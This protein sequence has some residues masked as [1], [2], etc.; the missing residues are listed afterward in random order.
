MLVISV[1]CVLWL[2]L[3]FEGAPLNMLYT[4]L[5]VEPQTM[6]KTKTENCKTKPKIWQMQHK[7]NLLG[8]GFRS[9]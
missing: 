9:G 5:C 3:L 2:L 1:V 7:Q 4:Y 6:M 8:R